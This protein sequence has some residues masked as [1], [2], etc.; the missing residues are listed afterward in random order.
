[1]LRVECT[2]SRRGVYYLHRLIEKHGRKGNM[3]KWREQLKLPYV[4]CLERT[5]Y[6]SSVS[7]RNLCEQEGDRRVRGT[8]DP[9]AQP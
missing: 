2:C 8:P 6:P 1:V 9:A 7:C 4:G 3:M 5:N